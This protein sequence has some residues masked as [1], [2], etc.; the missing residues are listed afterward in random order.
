MGTNEAEQRTSPAATP[1]QVCKGSTS[2]HHPPNIFNNPVTSQEARKALQTV[3]K[4]LEQNLSSYKSLD[5]SFDKHDI[6]TIRS[7][8][9]GLKHETLNLGGENPSRKVSD[10]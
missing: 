10:N 8:L 5:E 4:F 1:I 3:L 9:E 2:V 6:E 7:L